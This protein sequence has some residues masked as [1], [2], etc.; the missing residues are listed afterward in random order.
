MNWLRRYIPATLKTHYR[1]WQRHKQDLQSGVLRL[2]VKNHVPLSEKFPH[3]I[4]GQQPVHASH[5]SENKV[6][7]L[8][9]AAGKLNGR[10]IG[11]GQIFSFW[12]LVERPIEKNGYRKG[13]AIVQNR[14]SEVTGGG[15]CQ[16]SGIIYLLAIRAGL[17]V[18]ERHAHSLDLY[19]NEERFAPLGSDATV[20]W[21]YKDLRFKNNTGNRFYFLFNI[22]PAQVSAQLFSDQPLPDYPIEFRASPSAGEVKVKTIRHRDE[23]LEVLSEHTYQLWK[24]E[25][26]MNNQ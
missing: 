24:V 23:K 2:L 4:S 15:L 14:L 26:G 16:L 7:N 18:V 13:R 3:F 22:Q 21:A 17:P 12:N 19:Q 6:H 10:V 25:G 1:Q 9:L 20:A 5:L 8:L 11:P